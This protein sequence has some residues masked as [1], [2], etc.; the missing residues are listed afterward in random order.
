MPEQLEA[1]SAP[2]GWT[3]RCILPSHDATLSEGVDRRAAAPTHAPAPAPPCP[4]L[5]QSRCV[6]NIGSAAQ[7]GLPIGATVALCSTRGCRVRRTASSDNCKAGSP[8]PTSHIPHPLSIH[9]IVNAFT[10]PSQLVYLQ[11]AYFETRRRHGF[12]KRPPFFSPPPIHRA[13]THVHFI[14]PPPHAEP[15]RL[16]F[17]AVTL[18]MYGT[19]NLPMHARPTKRSSP[20]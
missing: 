10:V 11:D 1:S 6:R 12:C 18:Y 16:P 15:P 5:H 3:A 8:S 14:G 17:L 9:P 19:A 4:Q 2:D 13:H 20:R 7:T